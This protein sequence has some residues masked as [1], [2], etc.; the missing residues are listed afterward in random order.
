MLE[1]YCEFEFYLELIRSNNVPMNHF[2]ITVPILYQQHK[3]RWLY[4]VILRPYI[5]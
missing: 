3:S 1:L 4:S 5:I 2:E